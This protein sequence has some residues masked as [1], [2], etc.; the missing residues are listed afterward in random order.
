MIIIFRANDGSEFLTEEA[1]QE[2]EESI[3]LNLKPRKNIDW[4]P[5]IKLAQDYIEFIF[6]EKYHEDR[7]SDFECFIFESV[8]SQVYGKEIWES[9]NEKT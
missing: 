9:I 1:C 2:Y 4:N 3:K 7:A 8:I 6:S 5:V